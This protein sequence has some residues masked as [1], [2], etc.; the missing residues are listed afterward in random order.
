MLH[1]AGG[2]RSRRDG[3]RRRGGRAF[4]RRRSARNHRAQGAARERFGPCRQGRR[5]ARLRDD[6]R[7]SRTGAGRMDRGVRAGARRR[8]NALVLPAA[9][10][11]HGPHARA[12]DHLDHGAGRSAHRRARG[13]HGR[14]GGRSPLRVRLHR[15]RGA[16]ASR[17]AGREALG[18]AARRRL[19]RLP[20]RAFPA[21]AAPSCVAPCR[22]RSRLGRDGRVGWARR[23]S[24]EDDARLS[25]ARKGRTRARAAV[26]R[27]PRRDAAG[28]RAVRDRGHGRRRLRNPVQRAAITCGRVRGGARAPWGF[29][30][31]A[32]DTLRRTSI[33]ARNSSTA[34]ASERRSRAGRIRTSDKRR[35]PRSR[36]ASCRRRPASTTG[37]TEP[38]SRGARERE[39]GTHSRVATGSRIGLRPSGMWSA[40]RAALSKKLGELRRRRARVGRGDDARNDGQSVGACREHRR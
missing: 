17:A 29:L 24:R 16:R 38:H 7:L 3:G 5:S 22:A 33:R 37:C 26:G 36:H 2:L 13:A 1:A 34:M 31:R 4:P 12:A 32:S 30:S 15:R 21:S 35:R 14:E 28:A 20:H 19:A 27:G 18:G 9:G 23:R 39:P 6:H 8:F 10:R 11:R 25:G 40:P